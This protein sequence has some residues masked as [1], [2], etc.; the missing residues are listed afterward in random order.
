MS[1]EAQI[2]LQ[3]ADMLHDIEMATMQRDARLA[4][5]VTYH[6]DGVLVHPAWIGTNVDTNA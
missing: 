6:D 4:Y 1:T 2:D 5:A 3:L